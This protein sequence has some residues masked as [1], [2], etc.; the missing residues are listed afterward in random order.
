[1]VEPTRLLKTDIEEARAEI[2]KAIALLVNRF[3][4]DSDLW[5]HLQLALDRLRE[6]SI[7]R[8]IETVAVPA[9]PTEVPATVEPEEEVESIAPPLEESVAVIEVTA[10]KGA[11][12]G[13]RGRNKRT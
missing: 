8:V 12:R 4:H 7:P 2:Q 9:E 5:K 3:G 1:M 11:H 13:R 6:P 10:S